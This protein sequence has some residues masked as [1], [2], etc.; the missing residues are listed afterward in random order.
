MLDY[1]LAI[2][3]ALITNTLPGQKKIPNV[4]NVKIFV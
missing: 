4:S 2:Y 1:T 3:Y